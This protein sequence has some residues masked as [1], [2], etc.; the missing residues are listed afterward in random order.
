M[1]TR[2]AGAT[3]GDPQL[4]GGLEL[5]TAVVE[6]GSFV[7]AGE[8][9]GLSQS[10]TS[11]AIARLEQ[12]VGV[13]LFDRNARAVTLT[14]EG[15]RFHERV[16]PLVAQLA[17]AI[18]G[19]SSATTR[20]RGR[21]RVNVDMFFARYVLASR[22]DRFLARHPDLSVELI[23]RDHTSHLDLIAGGFDIAVRFDEPRATSLV[24]RRLLATRIMTCA[25]PAYLARHGRPRQ[26]RDLSGDHECIMFVDPKTGMPYDW[27][28]VRGRKRIRRVPV[29]GRLVVNDV[30]T[31]LGACLAGHGIAQLMELGTEQLRASGALV[32]LFPDWHDERF[33]LYAFHPSRHLPPAKVGAFLDFIVESTRDFAT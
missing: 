15:R 33:P 19:A 1:P 27:D 24:A 26:P 31:A 13:R 5:L 23:T 8:R 10:G 9:V 28:F 6:T 11:R 25:S 32:E 20:V 17:D 29:H 18:E 21:L 3:T 7:A 22:I 30:A 12:Q 2:R 4:L 14:D 16:A